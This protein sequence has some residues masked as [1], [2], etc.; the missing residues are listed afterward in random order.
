MNILKLIIR[1]KYIVKITVPGVV[2]LASLVVAV[3]LGSDKSTLPMVS[4]K[5][6]HLLVVPC[7]DMDI[8]LRFLVTLL[9][10]DRK[11]KNNDNCIY[12]QQVTNNYALQI[13]QSPNVT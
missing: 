6:D 12:G 4:I 3:Q 1:R 5:L 10:T 2:V 7:V 8:S 13:I 11:N 9:C